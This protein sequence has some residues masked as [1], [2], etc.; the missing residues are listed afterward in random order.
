MECG[1]PPQWARWD[2]NP[3]PL[4]RK[5]SVLTR[6][7]DGPTSYLINNDFTLKVFFGLC[8]ADLLNFHRELRGVKK[9]N[10]ASNHY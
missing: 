3:G 6:L 10:Y 5:G 9:R 2:L 1:Y 4:P 7:D 8:F